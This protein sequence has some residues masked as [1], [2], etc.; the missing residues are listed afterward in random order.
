MPEAKRLEAG[1]PPG[2]EGLPETS[3]I[4][5]LETVLAGARSGIQAK[6]A[7]LDAL[8]NAT[9][10]IAPYHDPIS[11]TLEQRSRLLEEHKRSALHPRILVARRERVRARCA[12]FAVFDGD[13]A[14]EQFAEGLLNAQ[15]GA[16]RR[17]RRE[18]A[19]S[20]LL[21]KDTGK[22]IAECRQRIARV[23]RL[24]RDLKAFFRRAGAVGCRPVDMSDLPRRQVA[25]GVAQDQAQGRS[26]PAIGRFACHR[27][28]SRSI[29]PGFPQPLA[30][31]DASPPRQ[32]C[33]HASRERIRR[34]HAFPND[35]ADPARNAMNLSSRNTAPGLRAPGCAGSARLS[36]AQ[37]VASYHPR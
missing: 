8:A 36:E 25:H 27:R 17:Q 33:R 19:D 34:R 12:A 5:A 7:P 6:E 30:E 3:A 11:H 10:R 32:R 24:V 4:A 23:R 16:A 35:A 28:P 2:A 13:G 14:L 26:G 18:G 31:R 21:R 29:E 1:A 15:A 20:P 9:V 37:D 22:L